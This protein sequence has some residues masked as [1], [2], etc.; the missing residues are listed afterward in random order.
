M[1]PYP[2]LLKSQELHATM[3][4]DMRSE[5]HDLKV[6]GK[7][8]LTKLIKWRGKILRAAEKAKQERQEARWRRELDACITAPAPTMSEWQHGV[9]TEADLA[10]GARERGRER[11][12]SERRV[13]KGANECQ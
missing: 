5:L 4:D 12:R 13:C 6:L 7:G 11:E 8:P 2:A 1:I 10:S 9:P 3:T